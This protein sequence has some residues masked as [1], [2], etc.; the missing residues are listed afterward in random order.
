MRFPFLFLL[1]MH[2]TTQTTQIT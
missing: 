1:M 2:M